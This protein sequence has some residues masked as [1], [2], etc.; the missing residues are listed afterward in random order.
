MAVEN[1]SDPAQAADR[2]NGGN[3]AQEQ[4][5]A[6]WQDAKQGARSMLDEQRH[7][8]ASGIGD[9]ANALRTTARN[10]DSGNQATVAR[11]A[12][13]AAD[14]LEQISSALQRRDLDGLVREAEGYAKRHPVAFFGGAVLA[15][16]LA[17]RFLKSTSQSHR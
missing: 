9:L 5:Q 17:V 7:T 13:G 10:L 8:A 16:F 11:V 14:S 15:G 6:L 2:G 1:M 4:A 12:R 3:Q